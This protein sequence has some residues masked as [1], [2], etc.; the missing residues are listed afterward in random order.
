MINKFL[1]ILRHLVYNYN[2]F[3]RTSDANIKIVK[4]FNTI[5]RLSKSTIFSGE[6]VLTINENW[7]GL[8]S[9]PCK[10]YL[11]AS[12]N[13]KFILHGDFRLFNGASIYLNGGGKA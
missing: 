6:G 3:Q 8:R 2:K 10:S 11:I 4:K 7:F 9:S 1:G 5:I 12:Q 13:S